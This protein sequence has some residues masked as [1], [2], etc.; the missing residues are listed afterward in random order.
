MEWSWN[1]AYKTCMGGCKYLDVAPG[2]KKKILE[3]IG[4]LARMDH[5]RIVNK[6]LESKPEGRRSRMG[7]PRLRWLGNDETYLMKVIK[8]RLKPASRKE[9]VSAIMGARRLRGTGA[10]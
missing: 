6:I 5:E 7:R 3:W 9:W 10:E 4:H 8:R 2:I 1:V